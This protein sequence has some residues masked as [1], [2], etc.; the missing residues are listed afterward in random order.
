MPTDFNEYRNSYRDAVDDAVSFSGAPPELFTRLKARHLVD[1]AERRLGDPAGL[2]V[3]DVGCGVGE[4]DR[5]LEGAFSELH[6]VDVAPELLAAAA[7]A[8][9]WASYRAYA[10]GEPIPHP[11]GAFDVGFAICVL[12]HVPP[13]D[14]ERFLGEIARVTRPGGV[15]AIFEHNPLNPLTRLTVAR[16]EFDEDAVLLTR[17]RTRGLLA[18]LGLAELEAP[19]IIPVPGEGRAAGALERGLARVPLGAQYYVAAE[20]RA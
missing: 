15:V 18:G 3:L 11:D 5:V 13:A 14:W 7:D 20:P 16:C 10:E 17:R 2:R 1:L 4:T 9:P 12:H 8:N 6:G 19:Y